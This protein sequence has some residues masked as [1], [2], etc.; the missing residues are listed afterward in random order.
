MVFHVEE[1]CKLSSVWLK[2]GK[3]ENIYI[4]KEKCISYEPMTCEAIGYSCYL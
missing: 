3:E 2:E 4:H 1:V